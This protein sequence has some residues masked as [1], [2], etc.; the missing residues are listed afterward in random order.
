M[1]VLVTGACGYKGTVLVPKLLADGHDVLAFDIMWFGNFLQPHPR[2][3]VVQGDIRNMEGVDL[4]GV[5][6]IVHLA[7]VAND[8]CSD[9]DQRPTWEIS[10]LATM[11][12][13]DKA[14]RFGVKRFVYASSGSGYG[15]KEEA[16][17][18]EDLE[19]TPIS[20]RNKTKTVAD[21][22]HELA[23]RYRAGEINGSTISSGCR[24]TW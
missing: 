19:L 4:A 20:D 8:P 11:Q 6:A 5:E 14:E 13:A 9:L 16:Q 15:V 3:K 17:V 2:L 10:A 22:I 1:R 18:T 24:G 23:Q 12:L 21:A 7:P